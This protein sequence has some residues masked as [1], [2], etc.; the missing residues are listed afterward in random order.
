LT[1]TEFADKINVDNNEIMKPHI[2]LGIRPISLYLTTVNWSDY[3]GK[4]R[5]SMFVMAKACFVMTGAQV[6]R[7]PSRRG[8]SILG[9]SYVQNAIFA[10]IV[11]FDEYKSK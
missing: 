7:F 4:L 8:R 10:E 5:S 3:E 9:F 2:I 11:A 1:K 6:D